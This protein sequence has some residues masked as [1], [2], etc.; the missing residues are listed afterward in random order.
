VFS[1]AESIIQANE[2]HLDDLLE[3]GLDLWKEDFSY[4]NLKDKF[5][6]AFQSAKNRV[7]LY[8]KAEKAVAF[9]VVSIRSDYVEGSESSPTGY[10]EGIYVKPKFRKTGIAGKLL[11]EA[12]KW[13]KG[14]GCKQIGSDTYIDNTLS[15]DFHTNM[16]FKEAGRL[17]TFIKDIK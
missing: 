1:N 17:I 9:I 11:T 5:V 7:L 13:V 8:I 3:M 10:V 16:G 14:K 12:E 15:Y 2:Q 6:D 4:E